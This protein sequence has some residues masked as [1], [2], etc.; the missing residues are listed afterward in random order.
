MPVGIQDWRAGIAKSV[1]FTYAAQF[2]S[3]PLR[4]TP[5][6][7]LFICLLLLFHP[8][9]TDIHARLINLVPNSLKFT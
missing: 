7:I 2:F 1:R 5:L 4:V 9:V 8:A 6:Y 3:F